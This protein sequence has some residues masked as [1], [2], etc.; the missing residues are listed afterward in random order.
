MNGKPSPDSFNGRGFGRVIAVMVH[1]T[2]FS[3]SSPGSSPR[4]EFTLNST[5]MSSGRLRF[6]IL[7]PSILSR[8]LT[9]SALSIVPTLGSWT[10]TC[11]LTSGCLRWFEFD[12]GESVTMNFRFLFFFFFLFFYVHN[13]CV[14]ELKG[15]ELTSSI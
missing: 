14:I 10:V 13:L 1:E 3:S 4:E 11:I 7:L 15:N 8:L 6:F 12:V 2:Q 5:C 9:T